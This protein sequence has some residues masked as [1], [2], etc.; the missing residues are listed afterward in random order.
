MIKSTPN[1]NKLRKKLHPNLRVAKQKQKQVHPEYINFRDGHCTKYEIDALQEC[2]KDY[3][4]VIESYLI[5]RR[6]GN[7]ISPLDNR[8]IQLINLD[9]ADKRELIN[10]IKKRNLFVV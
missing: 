8:V 9:I 10:L 6:I 4:E 7:R 1:Q 5:I 3:L 2:I